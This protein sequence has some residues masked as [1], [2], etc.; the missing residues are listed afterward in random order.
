MAAGQIYVDINA[1]SPMDMEE[2]G[3]LCN[4]RGIQFCDVAVMGIIPQHGHKVPLILSGN[5]AAAFAEAFGGFGMRLH[6]L[7]S[8]PGGASAIKM[9]RSIFMKGLTCLLLESFCAAERFGVLQTIVE[10][11]NQTVKGQSVEDLANSLIPR[12]LIHAK[13]R[14]AEMEDVQKTLQS[15][16]QP[17]QMS[18]AAAEKLTYI[19]ESG[20]AQTL[21]NE[22]P[23]DYIDAV[24]ALLAA[25]TAAR[26]AG[27]A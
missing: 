10:S 20:A 7:D 5:G 1:A 25:G 14:I 23:K 15:L 27:S 8:K 19:Y 13:R 24:R 12:T 4:V 11:L 17:C 26:D 9:F 2:I 22:V 3:N 18:K 6:A 16:G 21:N